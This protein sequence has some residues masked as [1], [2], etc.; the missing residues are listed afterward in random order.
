MSHSLDAKL[1][2]R[3]LVPLKLDFRAGADT[4]R[5]GPE[6]EGEIVAAILVLVLVTTAQFPRTRLSVCRYMH[7]HP[8]PIKT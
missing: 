3:D 2:P 8:D 6:T 4:Y 1:S 5:S 7:M